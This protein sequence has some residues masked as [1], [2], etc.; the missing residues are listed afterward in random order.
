MA[1]QFDAP[2]QPAG[3]QL[4]AVLPSHYGTVWHTS[5]SPDGRLVAASGSDGAIR[6]WRYTGKAGLGAQATVLELADADELDSTA[7]G[8]G[9]ELL[10][11]ATFSKKTV[12]SCEFSPDGTMIAAA[13]FDGAVTVWMCRPERSTPLHPIAKLAG[14]KHE[15]KSVAW[16]DDGALLGTCGRDQTVR[17]WTTPSDAHA[18]CDAYRA[19]DASG[20]FVCVS[21]RR[22]HAGDA[23]FM[24]FRPAS[25]DFVSGGYDNR[26]RVW[27]APADVHAV[28][29]AAVDGAGRCPVAAAAAKAAAAL[30]CTIAAATAAAKI[31]PCKAGKGGWRCRA[32]LEG[33]E[34]TVWSAAFAPTAAAADG[35][36][37]KRAPLDGCRVVTCG[38]D[39]SVRV[40]R[41]DAATGGEAEEGAEGSSG[42]GDAAGDGKSQCMEPVLEQSVVAHESRPVY[43]CVA[44]G[45][46]VRWRYLRAA[47]TLLSPSHQSVAVWRASLC[48]SVDWGPSGIAT[49]GGD[50]AVGIYGRDDASGEVFVR[51][52]QPG[53]HEGDVNCVRWHPAARD[54]LVTCSDD[55]SVRVWRVGPPSTAEFAAGGATT[56]STCAAAS[57]GAGYGVGAGYRAARVVR[58]PPAG[59]S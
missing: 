52:R 43:R 1:T 5:W 3:L 48:R 55:G 29:K 42:C 57:C 6:L 22:A 58:S 2:A 35:A 19:G 53:A 8:G 17:L 33:H 49:G 54:V 34:S 16:S 38:A 32:A 23:K 50:D 39:S 4:L 12:R 45:L 10:Q 18:A 47:P 21:A 51:A 59:A 24:R 41:L 20:G 37:G 15:V 13:G 28:A 27:A 31:R 30:R 25:H 40:W 26:S 46:G 36:D 9:W 11:C 56:P 7:D 14:H 44:T